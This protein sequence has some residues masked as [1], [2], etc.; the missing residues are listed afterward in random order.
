ML[1]RPEIEA[2]LTDLVAELTKLRRPVTIYIV[3]GTALMLG[4]GA[5]QATRDVDV[6]ATP[7]AEVLRAASE[8]AERRS[9]PD[10]W[11]ST[12]ASVFVP[13]HPE[14]PNPTVFLQEEGVRVEIASAEWLL[15][16]KIRAS[17]GRQ[18]IDDIRLLLEIADVRTVDDAV[19]VYERV[20]EEDPI[21]E[22]SLR[23]LRELV[24]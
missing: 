23:I 24:T 17:R 22:R 4:F 2:A 3:G 20:Y 19:A 15:G 9:L 13:P 16:M 18:D 6:V 1:S 12:A 8:V 11:L 10:D 5:R 7:P 14:D 21:G